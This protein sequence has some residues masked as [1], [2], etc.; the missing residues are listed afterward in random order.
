MADEDSESD[1]DQTSQSA[2]DFQ[3]NRPRST[4]DILYSQ[5]QN[6]SQSKKIKRKRIQSNSITYSDIYTESD[7]S[8]YKTPQPKRRL[9]QDNTPNQPTMV[10][11]NS[12]EIKLAKLNPIKIAKALNK[13]GKD[14]IKTGTKNNQGGITVQCM[15]LHLSP[16][17]KTSNNNT[18]RP[19]DSNRRICKITNSK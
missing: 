19:M 16:S 17:K 10:V 15:L 8:D 11:I 18:I 14:I 2:M 1:T 4:F 6:D 13:V 5:A 12:P 7:D 3:D 9:T